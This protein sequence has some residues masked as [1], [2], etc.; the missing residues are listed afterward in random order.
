MVPG[1]RFLP[2][3]PSSPE[4]VP[5]I[6]RRARAGRTFPQRLFYANIP[7]ADNHKLA[8]VPRYM[9]NIYICLANVE[10]AEL[11]LVQFWL[12]SLLS[13]VY[14]IPLKWEPHEGGAIWGE[15]CISHPPPDRPK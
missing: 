3:G 7:M 2:K 10:E 1:F 14:G 5:K 9:D 15:A 11:P 6:K 12:S 8:L 13:C 4:Q